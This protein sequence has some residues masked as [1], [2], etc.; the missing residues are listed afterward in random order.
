MRNLL[1]GIFHNLHAPIDE[2][3]LNSGFF[4]AMMN[5]KEFK[6]LEK[7]KKQLHL[8]DSGV[9]LLTRQEP[10][11]YIDLY[12]LDSFYVEAYYHCGLNK[13]IYLRAFTST[14]ELNPF[15]NLVDISSLINTV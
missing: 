8:F 6:K 1:S 3:P 5:I 10:E 2:P 15:L 9:F 12:Y 4:F 14:D 7:D 13:L 11:Y